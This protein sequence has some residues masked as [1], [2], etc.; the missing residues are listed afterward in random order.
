MAKFSQQQLHQSLEF[1][2]EIYAWR[3]QEGFTQ[4]L[5]ASLLTLIQG[6]VCSYNDFNNTTQ[7]ATYTYAPLS[8]PVLPNGE[9]IVS[10]C[11][12]GE[13]A[14]KQKEFVQKG[15]TTFRSLDLWTSSAQYHATP[16]YNEFYR[17]LRTPYFLM[18][19]LTFEGEKLAALHRNGRDFL[20]EE[21]DLLEIVRPHLAKAQANAQRVSHMQDH[22]QRVNGAVEAL[23]Q[24]VVVLSSKG[25]IEWITMVGHNILKTFWPYWKRR[26]NSL[27]TLLGNWVRSQLQIL[28]DPD[29]APGVQMTLTLNKGNNRLSVRLVPQGNQQVLF[30]EKEPIE[31][32]LDILDHYDLTPREKDVL[33]WAIKGKSNPDISQILGTSPETIQKQFGSIY[34]KLG[35]E[36]RAA[37]VATALECMR[38]AH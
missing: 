16:I 19:A 3:D 17:P 23:N 27:P 24:G 5:P 33:G 15:N 7:K 29:Y 26:K 22:L 1:L 35:V 31:L 37:A 30:L 4:Q 2:H 9:E 25:Q 28:D 14:G 34:Q 32:P 8:F 21:R 12:Q 20:E 13:E 11:A 36:N 6:D 38:L 18:T 10:H